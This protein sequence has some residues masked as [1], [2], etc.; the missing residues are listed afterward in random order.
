M[1]QGNQSGPI[2]CREREH[3]RILPLFIVLEFVK[4]L[5]DAGHSAVRRLLHPLLRLNATSVAGEARAELLPYPVDLGA[6][7]VGV[8][9]G[10]CQYMLGQRHG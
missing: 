9:L 5:Q 3:D 10:F 7:S 2:G 8:G 1:S 4:E 6:N